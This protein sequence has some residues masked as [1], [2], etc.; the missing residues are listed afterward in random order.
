VT[1]PTSS[2]KRDRKLIQ[3]LF[4]PRKDR[5]DILFPG[6]KHFYQHLKNKKN[7]RLEE[8]INKKILKNPTENKTH[9]MPTFRY[10]HPL[11]GVS[12]LFTRNP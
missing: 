10:I 2:F 9:C 11:S 1:L 8:K 7:M 5:R 6:L 4:H 3:T 12:P